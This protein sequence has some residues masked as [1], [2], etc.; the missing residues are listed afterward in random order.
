[1]TLKQAATQQ[2]DQFKSVLTE[3]NEHYTS[4]SSM[5][6]TVTQQMGIEEE[7]V[8]KVDHQYEQLKKIV[9]EQRKEA[10]N[11]IK[12]LESIQEYKPPPKDFSQN[13][14]TSM[15]TFIK[16]IEDHITKMQALSDKKNF[17]E[18]L[19]L[20]GSLDQF[21]SQ[22][23]SFKSQI[24]K[25]KCYLEENSRP[26]V[27]VRSELDKFRAFLHDVVS[28]EPDFILAQEKPRLHY[29][30]PESTT[31]LVHELASQTTKPINIRNHELLPK[32][33]VSI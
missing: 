28:F 9:D 15:E 6:N 24:A 2:I 32:D 19:R 3:S 22:T 18:V 20:R 17:F 29:Y 25:H 4:C 16:G 13:T 1:M 31:L 23:K 8:E 10:F 11:T 5:K 27:I 7:V 14:L 30:D 21:S 26:N 12:N 33:F